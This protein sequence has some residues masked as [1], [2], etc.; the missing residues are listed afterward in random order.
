MKMIILLFSCLLFSCSQSSKTD[1]RPRTDTVFVVG[2][3]KKYLWM[4]WTILNL[5]VSVIMKKM[6]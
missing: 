1:E 3:T 5:D 4:I 6:G 2:N